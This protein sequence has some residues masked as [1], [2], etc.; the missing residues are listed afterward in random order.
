MALHR[1]RFIGLGSLAACGT[2]LKPASLL[3]ARARNI[4]VSYTPDAPAPAVAELTLGLMLSLLR[5]VH[6]S[7]ATWPNAR[8]VTCWASKKVSSLWPTS[9]QSS[10]RRAQ[11][12]SRI[13][14]NSRPPT[15]A[16]ARREHKSVARRVAT[17]RE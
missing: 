7:N 8:C 6:V 17:S 2:V 9:L 13:V 14:R 5:S 10:A 12:I 3:A 4:L 16:K 11:E 15:S 1:R